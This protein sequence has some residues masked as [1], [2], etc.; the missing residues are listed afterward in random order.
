MPRANRYFVPGF[1]YHLT[2][3]CHNREFLLRYAGDR[4]RYRSLL[5]K[6]VIEFDLSVLDFCVTSNHTHVVTIAEEPQ[7]ISALM[8]RVEGEHAQAYNR[9][10][11]RSGAFWAD[12]FHST[13]I[14]S[15]RHLE[16]CLVYVALNMVR[17][18]V[19]SHPEQWRWCGYHELMGLR[20]RYR[21]LDL[22]RLL[23]LLGGVDVAQFRSNYAARIEQ[24]IA[25]GRM[26]REPRWTESVAVGSEGF[27]RQIASRIRGRQELEVVEEGERWLLREPDQAYRINREPSRALGQLGTQISLEPFDGRPYRV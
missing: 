25:E 15:G 20:Q 26:C 3:R 4:D 8:Q 7:L 9:R 12:R 17:C 1:A 27:V 10:N 11:Q 24:R 14:E 18:G 19:V 2:H 16:D 6:R 22:E 5:R 13:I 23:S 21:M